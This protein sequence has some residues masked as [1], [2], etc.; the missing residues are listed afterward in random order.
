VADEPASERR[1]I[2]LSGEPARRN[3][4]HGGGHLAEEGRYDR[5]SANALDQNR[6]DILTHLQQGGFVSCA[7]RGQHA[8]QSFEEP[9]GEDAREGVRPGAQ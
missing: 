9:T 8:G 3:G 1:L 5:R 6:A 7:R 4:E 2:A